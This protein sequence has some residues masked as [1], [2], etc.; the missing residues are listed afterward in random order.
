L[1]NYN[2][3]VVDNDTMITHTLQKVITLML[4]QNVIAFNNPMDALAQL[5]AKALKIDLVI[6]DYS[7]AQMTGIEFLKKIKEISPDTIRILLSG[8]ADK[9]NALKS[10]NEIGIFYGSTSIVGVELV[11]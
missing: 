11:K 5:E 10:M 4:K 9:H 3:L 7:M 1:K 6:S 8:Y 2:I